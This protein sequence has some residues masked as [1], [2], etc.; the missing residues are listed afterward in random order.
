MSTLA[1]LY[2]HG[3]SPPQD[4]AEELFA[5]R[6]R[7]RP[8]DY[9]AALAWARR[10]ADAGS[11]EAGA[12][13]AFI[14]SRGPEGLRD[15]VESERLY[16]RAAQEGSPQGSLGLAM[17]LL[18]RQD[19]S[20]ATVEEGAS[21]VHQAADAGLPT[22]LYVLG[23]LHARGFGA[24]RDPS[25]AL[26][27]F[28]RAAEK[29]FRPAQAR[30]G[31]ALLRRG[32]D[33]A[34]PGS[35]SRVPTPDLIEGETWLRRAALAGDTEAA[36]LV[37]D[38]YSRGGPVP[39]NYHEAAIW[40]RRAAENGHAQAARAL[41]LLFLLGRGMPEDRPEAMAWFRRAAQLGDQTA[42][43]DVARGLAAG[44]TEG[45]DGFALKPREWFEEPARSGDPLAAYNFAVC[46]A[47]GVGMEKDPAAARAWMRTAADSIVNAQYWYGYFLL[48]GIGGDTDTSQGRNWIARA[49]DEG[50]TEAQALLGEVL[51]NGRG[52]DRNPRRALELFEEAGRAGH[53]GALFG[54]AA[55]L[56]GGHGLPADREAAARYYRAAAE[57]RHSAAQLMLGRYLL[58][59]LAGEKDPVQGRFWL[60]QAADGG[61]EQAAREL[62]ALD[63]AATPVA[64]GR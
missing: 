6:S 40:F 48:H 46:L 15:L 36:A 20:R 62:A 41:G 53:A 27:L 8:A 25:A 60:Q 38:I 43:V 59:G 50:M 16:R 10:G 23:L 26:E 61:S 24:T 35:S 44:L 64:E 3:L 34:P 31:L 30:L 17:L 57:R 52:G 13:A 29:G 32:E 45:P 58:Q 33:A 7:G 49:A 22:A 28:R 14:L 5:A 51:L 21:L 47:E 56:G 55:I 39:P 37:G 2:L 63:Q 12:T 19:A 54:A 9:E 1:S 11:A 4:S 18:S 42:R